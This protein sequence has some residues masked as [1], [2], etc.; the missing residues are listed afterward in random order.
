[1]SDPADSLHHAV[2]V[3]RTIARVINSTRILLCCYKGC[4]LKSE[5]RN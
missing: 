4:N 2:N 5:D 3:T 1:M